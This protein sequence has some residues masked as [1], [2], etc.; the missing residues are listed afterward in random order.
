MK[1][2]KVIIIVFCLLLLSLLANTRHSFAG[3][4]INTTMTGN[5]VKIEKHKHSF[6][7]ERISTGARRYVIVNNKTKV[8]YEGKEDKSYIP[9][10]WSLIRKGMLLRAEGGLSLEA[11]IKATKLVILHK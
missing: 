10:S 7:L 1:Q 4:L 2:Y 3:A 9:F 5:V 8:Y 6:V 11:K